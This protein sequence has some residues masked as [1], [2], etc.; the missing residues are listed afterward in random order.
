MPKRLPYTDGDVFAVPLRNGGFARGVIARAAPRGRILLG[1][2]FGPKMDAPGFGDREPRPTDALLYLRFGDLGLIKG[3]WP[4]VGKVEHWN[5]FDWPMPEFVRDPLSGRAW[6][7]HY[8]DDDPSL[9]EYEY[10]T[11]SDDDGPANSLSG[12]VAVE[13][14]LTKLLG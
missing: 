13:I 6:R 11:P 3:E 5:R 2:F 14:K 8:A 4:I 12:Y 10:P 7:V 9:I 1:Y